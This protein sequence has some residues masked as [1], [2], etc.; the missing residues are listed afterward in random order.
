MR[1]SAL[2]S[3]RARPRPWLAWLLTLL[4]V[5]NQVALAGHLCIEGTRDTATTA[6]PAGCDDAAMA[7]ADDTTLACDSHCADPA[8]HAQDSLSLSVPALGG[9]V[10]LPA[11]PAGQALRSAYAALADDPATRCWRL[12]HASTVLLI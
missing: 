9:A 7:A 1:R 8:K 3:M 5:C 12:Q 11:T 4:L 6:M 10:P 2:Q